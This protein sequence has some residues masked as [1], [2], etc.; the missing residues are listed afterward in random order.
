MSIVQVQACIKSITINKLIS[1]KKTEQAIFSIVISW[2]ISLDVP[3]NVRKCTPFRI[4]LYML[5]CCDKIDI[6][7]KIIHTTINYRGPSILKLVELMNTESQK[8]HRI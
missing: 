3:Y 2:W 8:Q 1:R 6:N 5:L 4:N 7:E